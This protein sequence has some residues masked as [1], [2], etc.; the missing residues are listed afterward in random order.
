VKAEL[1][2]QLRTDEGVDRC[3]YTDTLGFWTIGVGRLIDR[4]KP[5]A[6]LR[7]DEIA[8]LLNNDIDDRINALTAKLPWFQDLDD[9]RKGVLLNMSFQLGTAGL[10]GFANTLQLVHEGKYEQAADAMLA[11]R[12]AQQTPNRAERLAEQM[13]S[14]KWQFAA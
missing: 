10:L 5:G 7:D 12:W 9:P 14:G 6:G 4:R 8:Y 3:A 13:R 11:S 2:Q 1:T